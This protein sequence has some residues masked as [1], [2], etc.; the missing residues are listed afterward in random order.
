MGEKVP[1]QDEKALCQF[2]AVYL[3]T[4]IYASRSRKVDESSINLSV[5][6]DY[7]AERYPTE[8][9]NQAKG[10]KHLKFY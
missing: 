6:Q 1:S 9:E 5:L 4:N 10:N 3:G 2:K 8:G 7:I